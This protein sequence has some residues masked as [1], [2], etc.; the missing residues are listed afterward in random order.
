MY[1]YMTMMCNPSRLKK[2]HVAS[3]VMMVRLLEM[4]TRVMK[5]TQMIA[6][7]SLVT[8]QKTLL[9]YVQC[10]RPELHV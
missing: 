1:M 3:L 4:V 6:S 2:E 7:I 10:Y 9:R 5:G 8:S